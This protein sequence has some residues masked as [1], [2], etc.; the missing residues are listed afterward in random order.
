MIGPRPTATP[1]VAAQKP[2]A[3]PR[4]W[5]GK[6]LVMIESVDGMMHAAPMPMNARNAIS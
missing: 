3:R 4:S 6:R 1:A 5:A 2:I